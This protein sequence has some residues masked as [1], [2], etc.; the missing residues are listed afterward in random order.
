M[1]SK[2]K[3]SLQLYILG[4][5]G[6]GGVAV[7]LA[8]LASPPAFTRHELI[9][10]ALI[11]SLVTLTHLAPVKFHHRALVLHISL[12]AIAILTLRSS[13]AAAVIGVAVLLG[14]TYLRRPWFNVLF[15]AAQVAL[16][17]VVAGSV[18]RYLSPVSLGEPGYN[19]RSALAFVPA[20][21]LLYLVTTAAVDGVTAVHGRRSPFT[22]WFESHL[23]GLISH[24]A[25][26][27]VGGV[28]AAAINQT[29]W[30]MLAALVPMV[31]VRSIVRRAMGFDADTLLLAE[32][33]A[34]AVEACHPTLVGRSKRVAELAQDVARVRGLHADD[35]RRVYLAAR[36]HDIGA[37]LL[38]EH[39]LLD[40]EMLSEQQRLYRRNHGEDAARLVN[41]VLRLANVAETLR[42][43]HERFDGRGL[44]GTVGWSGPV[45]ARI[46]AI[47]EAWIGLTTAT[48][49]RPALSEAQALLVMSAGAGNQWDPDLVAMLTKI[50]VPQPSRAAAEAA[51]TSAL[52][53]SAA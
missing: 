48:S 19:L 20:G 16:S 41:K 26:V 8:L 25:L 15:N 5:I 6:L 22:R 18:Y 49:Y 1:F 32:E 53:R 42:Y 13:E 23:P 21:L 7:L 27:A 51:P 10:S 45:D 2:Q 43:H 46:L 35:C 44:L 50:I 17:V 28:T 14:N 9:L 37:A 30:L 52:L 39:V 24:I 29:P 40:S 12:Q 3:R 4:L 11:V 34:D 38:P 36:L 31:A 33:I 47:C